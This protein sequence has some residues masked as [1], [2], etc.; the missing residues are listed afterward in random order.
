MCKA[1]GTIVC[2]PI[3]ELAEAL[4]F[5]LDFVHLKLWWTAL[6]VKS[7]TQDGKKGDREGRYQN[8][9][10]Q[11]RVCVSSLIVA[12]VKTVSTLSS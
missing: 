3:L 1:C 7:M 9:R 6:A 4:K 5:P 12:L 2:R 8:T 10:D 11:E